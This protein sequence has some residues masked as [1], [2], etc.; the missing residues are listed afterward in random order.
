MQGS[1]TIANGVIAVA[2]GAFIDCDSLT[3]VSF[4]NTVTLVGECAFFGLKD[5]L[6]KISFAGG[7]NDVVIDKYAFRDC[8]ALHSVVFEKNSRI[9]TLEEGAFY[10][11]AAITSIEFPAAF[12][13]IGANAF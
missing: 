4:P 8:A 12:T 5:S 2:N 7:Y 1:F 3:E 9:S 10:G 6:T 13:K 11:C